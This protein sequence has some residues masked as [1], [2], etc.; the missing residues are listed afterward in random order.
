MSPRLETLLVARAA[1]AKAAAA[2]REA[3]MAVTELV[4]RETDGTAEQPQA[5]ER[6]ERVQ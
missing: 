2:C 3:G 4:R 5:D 6:E 1:L